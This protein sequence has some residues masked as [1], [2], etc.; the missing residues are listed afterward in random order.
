MS[1]AI[2]GSGDFLWEN[3]GR[4]SYCKTIEQIYRC[5]LSSSSKR[6]IS[7]SSQ[8]N[9]EFW[10]SVGHSR[11]GLECHIVASVGKDR[12][13]RKNN[14][15]RRV[16]MAQE[17]CIIERQSPEMA[18]EFIR[19]ASEKASQCSRRFAILMAEADQ[20]AA[21][22]EEAMRKAKQDTNLLDMFEEKT[23][24]LGHSS[25]SELPSSELPSLG[26]RFYKRRLWMSDG[27]LDGSF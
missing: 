16:L 24:K 4:K 17:R 8:K 11:R 15:I 25:A 27:E 2:E 1:Q 7:P 19:C 20:A 9:L 5:V 6:E 18:C 26:G 10:V 21:L 3:G 14:V 13:R 23:L 22:R 12:S